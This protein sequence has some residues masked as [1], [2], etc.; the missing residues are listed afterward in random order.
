M[1]KD[2]CISCIYRYRKRLLHLTA[3]S[4]WHRSAAN[5]TSFFS[6]FYINC[7]CCAAVTEISLRSDAVADVNVALNYGSVCVRVHVHVV[8]CFDHTTI[9][10][11]LSRSVL[12]VPVYTLSERGSHNKS[13]TDFLFHRM[14]SNYANFKCG[15]KISYE[16]DRERGGNDAQGRFR[17]LIVVVVVVVFVNTL[18]SSKRSVERRN[19]IHAPVAKAECLLQLL[20]FLITLITPTA[21]R[22]CRRGTGKREEELVLSA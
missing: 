2:M 11:L 5:L 7:N 21:R 12:P 1:R 17:S 4:V 6:L 18:S 8:S 16:R 22:Q 20:K 15:L 3:N 9:I 10:W 19:E 13:L 14:S